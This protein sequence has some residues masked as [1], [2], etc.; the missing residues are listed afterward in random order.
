M[1]HRDPLLG[2]VMLTLCREKQLFG[3]AEEIM[4]VLIEKKMVKPKFD[5]DGI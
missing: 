1:G 2:S 4:A 3:L 5:T